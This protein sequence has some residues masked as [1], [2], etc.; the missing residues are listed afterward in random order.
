MLGLGCRDC[1]FDARLGGLFASGFERGRLDGTRKGVE[2]D[3]FLWCNGRFAAFGDD[4][5]AHAVRKHAVY[6]QDPRR[7]TDDILSIGARESGR[8]EP[9]QHSTPERQPASLETGRLHDG[10]VSLT[11]PQDVRLVEQEAPGGDTDE[12]ESDL[13][14]ITGKSTGPWGIAHVHRK[15]GLGVGVFEPVDTGRVAEKHHGP[16]ACIHKQS[17]GRTSERRRPPS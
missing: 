11:I 8:C 10:V 16:F 4:V 1:G 3:R 7:P 2:I 9:V 14:H 5:D 15:L 17:H 12:F 13:K 6:I